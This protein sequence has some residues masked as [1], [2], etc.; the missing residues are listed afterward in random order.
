M[1]NIPDVDPLRQRA[2]ANSLSIVVAPDPE[3]E[4]RSVLRSIVADDKPFHRIAV[5]YRQDNPYSSLL[6]Q[7]LDFAEHTLLRSG[8]PPPGRYPG[9]SAT[10]GIDRPGSGTERSRRDD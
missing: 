7:E 5:I 6:R 2:E 4:V 10:A 3:E 1:S 8:L 9:G